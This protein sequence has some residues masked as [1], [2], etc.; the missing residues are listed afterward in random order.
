MGIAAVGVGLTTLAGGG[1]LWINSDGV[2]EMQAATT[3]PQ[4]KYLE[5]NDDGT[6]TIREEKPEAPLRA[7][8]IP[9]DGKSVTL[10]KSP[11]PNTPVAQALPQPTAE[12]PVYRVFGYPYGAKPPEGITYEVTTTYNGQQVIGAVWFRVDTPEG[13]VPQMYIQATNVTILPTASEQP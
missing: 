3:N 9:S 10:Y 5:R 8:L 11:N 4:A 2:R 13:L 7:L 6:Y 12:Y 1:F